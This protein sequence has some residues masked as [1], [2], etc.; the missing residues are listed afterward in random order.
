VR[1]DPDQLCLEVG[2]GE[3]VLTERLATLCPRLIAYEIDPHLAS[4]LEA[5]LGRRPGAE[6]IAG[7][8]LAAR[9]PAEPFQVVGNVPFSLTSAIVD[10]CLQAPRITTATII[11]QLEYAKKRAGSF[12]RWSLL[13]V[14]TW[15]EFSWELRGSIPRHQFRPV[16]RVDAG[17]LL[18]AR[19]AEPLLTGGRRTAY[20]RLV[21][22][23]FTGVGGTLYASLS[24]RYPGPALARAFDAAGLDRRTVVA[25]VHPQQWIGLCAELEPRGGRGHAAVPGSQAGAGRRTARRGAQPPGTR[26][27][28]RQTIAQA[29]RGKPPD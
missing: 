23:G 9:P 14:S 25:F 11:T 20:S 27:R 18:L 24:R 4:K 28:P 5:R 19:R 16:P 21:E 22:L 17:I 12:S 15:P 13:T 6:V 3:G 10:W 2:A 8:F 26:N 29:I 1:V 7:D